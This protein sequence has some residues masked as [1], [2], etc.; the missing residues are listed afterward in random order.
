[1]GRLRCSNV[2][3]S[4]PGSLGKIPSK[5]SKFE[6]FRRKKNP[7]REKDFPSVE[8]VATVVVD[9]GTISVLLNR[10][11]HPNHRIQL[12]GLWVRLA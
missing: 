3:P 1:M 5:I 12:D 8:L 11:F 9:V 7:F 10:L 6:S 4:G 2:P